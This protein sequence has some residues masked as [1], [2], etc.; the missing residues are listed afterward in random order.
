MNDAMKLI[1][2]K[3]QN[4]P[5][6][7]AKLAAELKAAAAG[8]DDAAKKEALVKAAKSVLGIEIAKD[9]AAQLKPEQLNAGGN[10][11]INGI[12]AMLFGKK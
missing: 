7:K 12:L 8:E 4:N 2:E 1:A 6:L 5:A 9:A 11:A 10:D 3:V